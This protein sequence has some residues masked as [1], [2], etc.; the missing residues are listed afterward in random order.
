MELKMVS[1]RS[2]VMQHIHWDKSVLDGLQSLFNEQRK[3]KKHEGAMKKE[4]FF[5]YTPDEP[6]NGS[7]CKEKNFSEMQNVYWDKLMLDGLQS[8]FDE[9]RKRKEV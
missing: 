6:S 8:L 5:I 9:H 2:I 3:M 7:G 4:Q 1:E